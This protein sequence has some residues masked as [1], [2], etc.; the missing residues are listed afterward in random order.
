MQPFGSN[1]P[2][3]GK[4]QWQPPPNALRFDDTAVDIPP[5]R[6]GEVARWV[7]SAQPVDIVPA[8]VP[9]IV[10]RRGGRTAHPVMFRGVEIIPWYGEVNAHWFAVVPTRRGDRL[11]EALTEAQLLGEVSRLLQLGPAI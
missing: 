4:G 5:V 2:R 10:L 1:P 11:A 8:Q 9:E 7:P 3:P 6:A